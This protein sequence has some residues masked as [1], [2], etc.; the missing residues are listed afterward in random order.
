MKRTSGIILGAIVL[1]GPVVAAAFL[2]GGVRSG[3][4]WSTVR[5]VA[6]ESDDWG[7]AGFVPSADAWEDLDRHELETGR[8][9]EVYW[10]STLEDSAMVAALN[11]TLAGHVGRDGH[12]A[13]MQP[14]YVMSSLAHVQDRW[15]KYD[16]PSLP[17]GYRRPGLWQAVAQGIEAGTWY[18]EFHATWHYDPDH[19]KEG[20]LASALAREVTARG[21]MLF[22]GSEKAK[23]L[24]AWRSRRVLEQELDHSLA[25][26]SSLF[27][28]EV[29]SVM[30]P[31]Y[32]WDDRVESMWQSRGIRVIQ[33]KREQINPHWG[34]GRVGR[35]RKFVARQ[36]NRWRYPGRTYLERN[37]RL[38]PVQAT[39]PEAVVRACILDTRRAWSAGQPAIVESHRVNFIHTDP[40]VVSVG[41]MALDRYLSEI[42]AD[43]R[44]T[45][46]FLTD[47][48]LAQIQ[49]KGTSWAVRGQ[50]VVVRNF[51][52]GTKVVAVPAA[53][54]AA[55]SGQVPGAFGGRPVLVKV[56]PGAS[57]ELVP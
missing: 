15:E 1:T 49:R 17:P 13:V 39:D 42:S 31:D 10:Q 11:R 23:E 57:F 33:G 46:I 40:G 45:P 12:P 21:I 51:T 56:G 27:G 48:E 25:V 22:P 55:V 34:S 9:P 3:V 50:V 54:M 41:L 30:A 29:N 20:A 47:H 2:F 8:F 38:E 52:R 28:R 16:L 18:P 4:D 19:R 43:G 14:N 35:A 26:F 24:G 6:I 44:Q 32:H 5:A 36:W 7:L 37:C 53:T